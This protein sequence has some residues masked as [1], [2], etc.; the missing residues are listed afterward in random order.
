M[1]EGLGLVHRFYWCPSCDVYGRGTACWTCRSTRVRWDH[2]PAM[3]LPAG[4]GVLLREL[5][6]RSGGR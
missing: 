6:S 1:V 2:V 4:Q 5:L 3:K